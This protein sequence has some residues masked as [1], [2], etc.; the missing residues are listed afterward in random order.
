MALINEAHILAN[1][2]EKKVKTDVNIKKDNLFYKENII[3][4]FKKFMPLI[5][6]IIL[7]YLIVSIG[8]DKIL[9]T[10]LKISPIY[11]VI[12][13]AINIPRVLIRNYSWQLIFKKQRIKVSFTKSLKIYLIGYY[14]GVITPGYTGELV[15]I[16][17]LKEESKEPTGKLFI[18][19]F[20]E[21]V[22]HTMSLNFMMI[23]GTILII[24]ELPIAFPIATAYL[25][26]QLVIYIY[27]FKKERGENLFNFLINLLTP[28][29]I[30][31]HLLKFTGTF[32]N[33]FPRLRDLVLPFILGIPEWILIYSSIY[34]LGIP[35]GITVPYF[36]FILIY[37]IANV[38]SFIPIT[39]AGLGTR[40]AALI[41]LFSF[42]GVPAQSALVLS[43]AGH[44]FTDV[45]CGFVGLIIS[46]FEAINNKKSVI[47][48]E[49]SFK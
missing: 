42:Y 8:T 31:H 20:I 17:Y 19:T 25:L 27:L 10:I 16:P 4:F 21:V 9:S 7:I 13:V 2:M 23:F 29:K 43:L 46:W 37:P 12:A 6:V 49:E 26:V 18:N 38:I 14:Y 45:L 30:R 32:Y 11:I 3:N 35:L 40:E 36:E 44:I 39:M 48:L 5:G 24:E 34:I 33:D 41:L 15:R 22:L 28:K 1:N 47:S